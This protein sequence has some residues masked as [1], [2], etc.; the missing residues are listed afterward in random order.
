VYTKKGT[1]LVE[2][3]KRSGHVF[4]DQAEVEPEATSDRTN[5]GLCDE[6]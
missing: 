3:E 4:L 1:P 6:P 2:D 5:P